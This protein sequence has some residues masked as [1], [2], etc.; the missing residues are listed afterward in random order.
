MAQY[1]PA[2]AAS[3]VAMPNNTGK[4]VVATIAGGT[5]TSINVPAGGTQVGT[6]GPAQVTIPAG[7]SLAITYSVAPTT[8]V[9][10][11]ET[12]AMPASTVPVTNA[13]GQGMDVQIA[14]GTVTVITVNGVVTGLTSGT[15]YVPPGGTIAITYSV[16]PVWAWVNPEEVGYTPGYAGSQTG[17]TDEQIAMQNPIHPEAGQ[18]GLGEG[19]TN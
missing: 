5:L 7:S 2:L 6:T 3:T 13:T 9:W 4:P 10:S 17:L 16:A 18:A 8:F 12:P 11:E 14:G 1:T 15:V 19:V